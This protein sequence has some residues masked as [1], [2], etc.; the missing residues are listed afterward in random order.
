MSTQKKY[1]SEDE[2]S[3]NC[4]YLFK[5]NLNYLFEKYLSPSPFPLFYTQF[6]R[7]CLEILL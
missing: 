1:L 7:L 3:P 2:Y 5:F 4:M 6:E